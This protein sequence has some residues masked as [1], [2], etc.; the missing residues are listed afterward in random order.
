MSKTVRTLIAYAPDGT[1]LRRTTHHDYRFCVVVCFDGNWGARSW[2]TTALLAE[3][4]WKEAKRAHWGPRE[5]SI[6]VVPVFGQGGS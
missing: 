5:V 1:E 2:H 4:A 3:R 6:Q